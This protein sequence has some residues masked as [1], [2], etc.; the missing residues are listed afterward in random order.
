MCVCAT[1][2]ALADAILVWIGQKCA[3]HGL[4]LQSHEILHQPDIEMD[5]IDHQPIVNT[6]NLASWRSMHAAAL[7]AI[8]SR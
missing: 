3:P 7:P 1:Q 2:S 6:T 4:L 5:P 8:C